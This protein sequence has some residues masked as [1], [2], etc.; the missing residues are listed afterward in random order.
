MTESLIKSNG[1]YMVFPL[2]DDLFIVNGHFRLKHRNNYRKSLKIG[3]MGVVLLVKHAHRKG[4]IR[5]VRY[6][7]KVISVVVVFLHKN[8]K[9][10]TG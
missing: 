3:V 5:H 1:M 8:S 2:S 4:N 6:W 7:L 9:N 10:R